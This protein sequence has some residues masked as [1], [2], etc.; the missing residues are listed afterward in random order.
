MAAFDGAGTGFYVLLGLITLIFI[1]ALGPGRRNRMI[2]SVPLVMA[3][4]KPEKCGYRLLVD[5]EVDDKH[6][7]FYIDVGEDIYESAAEG[8]HLH[9]P[10]YVGTAESQDARAST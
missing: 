7:E 5:A 1:S 2:V 8:T 10:R 3:V 9:N 6:C 4:W